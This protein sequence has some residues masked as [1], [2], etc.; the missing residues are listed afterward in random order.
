M[1]GI[2][3][4]VAAIIVGTV[5]GWVFK[6][7][8]TDKY[9]ATFWTALGLAALGVGAQTVVANLPKSHYPVLFIISLAI[10]LPVGTWLRL[11]DRANAWI[12]RTFHTEL[13]EAVAT[14]SFL[15]CIGALAILGPVNAATTG[16]QTF[17]Y[18]N[19]MLTLV[20][21][22]VFGAGFGL[23][24]ILEVPV[25]FIWFTAI[26][27]VAKFLSASFFSPALITEMSIVGGLLIVATSFSLL[28][29]REFKS[30]DML[31]ALLVPLLF[32]IGLAIF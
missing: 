17:L 31:P 26:Y 14:A 22:I 20:C 32:F 27:L 11:D 15:D 23:G 2:W 10:G 29:I 21:A 13:G 12:D 4:N 16:N 3:A 1:I 9:V 18:T 30:I 28:K 24:M 6:K 25:L 7:V 19:A 5:I 8:L